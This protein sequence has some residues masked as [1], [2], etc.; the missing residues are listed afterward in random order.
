MLLLAGL[1]YTG[2]VLVVAAASVRSARR[3]L[4][5]ATLGLLV[6]IVVA[7][8]ATQLIDPDQRC[9]YDCEGRFLLDVLGGLSIAA[10]VVG[11]VIGA[12]SG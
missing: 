2:V 7:R 6:S 12:S 10:W 8:L 1:I 3:R 4:V 11:A 5:V 9:T